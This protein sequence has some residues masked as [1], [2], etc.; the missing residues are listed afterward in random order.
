MRPERAIPSPRVHALAEFTAELPLPPN[1]LSPNVKVHWAVK[2]KATKAYREACAWAFKV[3]CPKT[4][5]PMAVVIDVSYRA[6][7]GCG[8]YHAFDVQNAMASMKASLDG[9]IDAGVVPSDGR[10]WVAWGSMDLTTT[11]RELRG[12]APGISVRVRA[13]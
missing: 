13:A 4:W 12:R 1:E 2:A 3:A 8:G 6:F 5:I 9:A 11:K 7:R 10:R